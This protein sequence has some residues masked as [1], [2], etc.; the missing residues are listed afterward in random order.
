[1]S[2]RQ[3]RETALSIL[4]CYEERGGN[5]ELIMAD[6]LK[7]PTTPDD[8]SFIRTLVQQTIQ[9]QEEIDQAIVKV[10]KNWEYQR[11]SLIDKLIL[12]LGACEILYLGKVPFQV[13]INE[14]I[15]IGKKYSSEDSGK[16]ING[17][18]DAIAANAGKTTARV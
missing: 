16:F 5:I 4:Y 8:R 17:I 18:L 14:A 12:R 13:A 1:M 3:A 9:N 11:V 15:E 10:L 6:F 2:R 7:S